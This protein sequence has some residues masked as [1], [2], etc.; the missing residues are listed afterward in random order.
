MAKD[1]AAAGIYLRGSIYW[2]NYQNN[3]VRDFVSLDTRD[4]AAA[5]IEARRIRGA[6]ALQSSGSFLVEINKFL[7]YKRRKN[8]FTVSSANGRFYILR[9]FANWVNVPPDAV[10]PRQV[11]A[12]YNE[13]LQEHSADT[14]NSYAMILRSFYNW[15]VDVAR[16]CQR[17]PCDKLD[18]TETDFR[19]L[20]LKDFCSEDQRDKLIHSCTR[21]DLAFVEY[22]GFHAGLRKNEI[23]EARPWWFDLKAG[24]LHLRETPTIKFKDREERTIPLTQEFQDFLVG[25]GL[26]EP[27]MLRPEVKHGKNRYRYDFTRPFMQHVKAQELEWIGQTHLTPHLMRHTFA[28]LLASKGVSLYKISIWLG[29]DPVTTAKTYARLTPKDPDIES[30]DGVLNPAV[31]HHL[32]KECWNVHIEPGAVL[33]GKPLRENSAGDATHFATPTFRIFPCRGTAL[34]KLRSALAGHFDFTMWRAF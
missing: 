30:I 29:D 22:S 21:E 26:R 28:S 13:K 24:L 7:A 6:G 10:T 16:I 2:L 8:E 27:Y 32:L 33:V 4:Y 25:Y 17:N 20:R 34:A 11:Q 1:P 3:G 19:G 5:I 31:L 23:I 15:A 12:F 9:A 18:I 14:A